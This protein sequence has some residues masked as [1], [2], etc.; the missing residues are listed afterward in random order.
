MTI[1]AAPPVDA[2][3][4]ASSLESSAGRG[5]L[6]TSV[7]LFHSGSVLHAAWRRARQV[8]TSASGRAGTQTAHEREATDGYKSV[9]DAFSELMSRLPP[10]YL[11]D[12]LRTEI[13]PAFVATQL[14]VDD[15]TGRHAIDEGDEMAM[16][17][18]FGIYTHSSAACR[19]G[20]GEDSC[21][22]LATLYDRCSSGGGG[23]SQHHHE[24]VEVIFTTLSCLLLDGLILADATNEEEDGDDKI[25]R[26]MEV[27]Q[28]L[29]T[30]DTNCCLGD[31]Q[32]WQKK[33]PSADRPTTLVQAVQNHLPDNAQ[34]DYLVLML[35]SSV[36]S[37][38]LSTK[39]R[40]LASEEP[41]HKKNASKKGP[42]RQPATATT[43][44]MDRLIAQVRDVLPNLGEGYVETALAAYSLDASRT[45]SALLEAEADPTTLHPRLRAVD[46]TLGRRKKESKGT[47]EA[48][49]DDDEEAREVQKTRLREM[50]KQAE[51]EAYNIALVERDDMYNDDYDDQYDGLGDDAGAAGEVGGAD[52]GLYDVDLDTMRDYNRAR[53]EEEKEATFWEESRNLNRANR[54]GGKAKAKRSS[55]DEGGDGKEGSGD[56]QQERI[57]RGPDKGKGGRLIGPD[58]K[59]L[60]IKKGGKKGKKQQAAKQ[61]NGGG[62]SKQQG[63]GKQQQGKA[64]ASGGA[65]STDNMSKIQKRRKDANKAKVGNH[66]RKER[67]LKK[68]G[69]GM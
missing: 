50:E 59:Y 26:V 64:T 33:A 38:S 24:L 11:E 7:D 61:E 57:Y 32:K 65:G 29:T 5:Q 34:R 12:V 49:G 13:N 44:A 6:P 20:V 17:A 53:R 42:Q 36:T 3:T 46:T 23:T 51:K 55:D 58:G 30:E 19:L 56:D 15:L 18:L 68:A 9:C 66:H 4:L 45:V 39:H 35:E 25:Q 1:Q 10:P 27:V 41:T 16:Q 43:N 69:R 54:R 37:E 62:N 67:A 48:G 31:F 14:Q 63:G 40:A 52:G 2:S 28:A 22:A 47:Y 8:T 21:S 60:P